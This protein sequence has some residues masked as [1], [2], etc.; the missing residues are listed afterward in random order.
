MTAAT[1]NSVSLSIIRTMAESRDPNQKLEAVYSLENMIA[2]G[3]MSSDD[4]D[5]VLSILTF[6]ACEG[7]VNVSIDSFRIDNDHSQVRNEAVRVLGKTGH[8]GAV[9][10]LVTV[11]LNESMTYVLSTAVTSCGQL[12]MGNKKMNAAFYL[13]LTGK[14][15]AFI[16]DALVYNTLLAIKQIMKVDDS[17]MI[18]SI[19]RDGVTHVADTESGFIRKT[20]R[21]AEEIL[22][23]K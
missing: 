20:R 1:D 15:D 22:A 8:P 14:K 16:S 5:G 2:K 3:Q 19:L 13:I 6:L 9:E 18:S 21:L 4:S 12:G 11:I 23:D 17:L 7:I 10:S